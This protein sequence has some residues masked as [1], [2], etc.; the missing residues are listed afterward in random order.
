MVARC[1]A[2]GGNTNS[3][4]LCGALLNT[5]VTCL[6]MM[7][8]LAIGNHFSQYCKGGV[9]NLYATNPAI[10]KN[11]YNIVCFPAK[12]SGGILSCDIPYCIFQDMRGHVIPPEEVVGKQNK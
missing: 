8:A 12:L 1:G 2:N 6:H 11:G 10:T 5:N 4:A 7:E 9:G 3:M